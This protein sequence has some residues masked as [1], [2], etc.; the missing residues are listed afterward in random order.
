MKFERLAF[1]R[2]ISPPV[3][4][5]TDSEKSTVTL[6]ALLTRAP[7]VDAITA[8]GAVASTVNVPRFRVFEIFPAASVTCTVQAE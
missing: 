5:R 4:P 8:T 3:N 7:E 2:T 1:E 6:N